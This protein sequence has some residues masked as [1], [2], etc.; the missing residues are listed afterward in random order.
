MSHEIRTPMNGVIGMTE[1]LQGTDLDAEN[2]Q[3]YAAIVANEAD[4][5]LHIINNILDFAK[6][7]A[8]KLLLDIQD[9]APA[10]LLA[11]VAELATTKASANKIA[12]LTF[13]TAIARQG[14]GRRRQAPSNFT[15]SSRQCHQIHPPR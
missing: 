5:L 1:L 4:H 8:D 15:Q 12:L 11:K 10:H 13:I 6:I 14:A 3:E 2:E 9:F 7:E